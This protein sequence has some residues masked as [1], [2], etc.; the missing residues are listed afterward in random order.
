MLRISLII[1]LSILVCIGCGGDDEP[2]M[3]TPEVTTLT[4]KVRGKD[5]TYGGARYGSISDDQYRVIA[6]NDSRELVEPCDSN[7][8]DIYID[9]KP[10]KTMD[11]I[12]MDA[13]GI[14]TGTTTITFRDPDIFQNIVVDRTGY[15][16]ITAETD[17]T[18]T[19]DMDVRFNDDNFL[20]GIFTAA[21]CF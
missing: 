18:L 3:K 20:A 19:I 13:A 7:T 12:E 16:Q 2:E 15:Y 4:G 17:S 10:F 11:R 1:F 6:F 14:S 21:K 5:F 9:F 8:E